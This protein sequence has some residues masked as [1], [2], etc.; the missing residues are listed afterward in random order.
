MKF[1]QAEMFPVEDFGFFLTAPKITPKR[2]HPCN[3]LCLEAKG[4]D[5]NCACMGKNHGRGY[6]LPADLFQSNYFGDSK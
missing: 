4:N 5:C 6:E 1:L 2:R 3:A